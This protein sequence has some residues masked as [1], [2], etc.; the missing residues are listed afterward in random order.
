MAEQII[1]VG[2][3]KITYNLGGTGAPLGAQVTMGVN[4]A[5]FAL[6]TAVA[7]AARLAFVNRILPDISNTIQLI[8]VRA[9]NGPND[10]GAF[11][12]IPGAAGGGATAAAASP[13]VSILVRKHT[14]SGGRKARG[15]LFMPGIVETIVDPSGII[16]AANVT[17]FQ[18]D[19]SNYLADMIAAG[20]TPCILHTDTAPNDV[21]SMNVENVVATQ[22]RRQRR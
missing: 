7:T 3:S 4:N 18:T 6:P 20:F 5:G 8:S 1:P 22:R 10:V 17:T 12:E 9:K 19:W 15:R 11:A 2:F 14:A 13:A 16:T 21:N